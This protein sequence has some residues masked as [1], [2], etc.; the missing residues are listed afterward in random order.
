MTIPELVHRFNKMRPLPYF[1]IEPM[2]DSGE[3]ALYHIEVDEKGVYTSLYMP[4]EDK[5]AAKLNRIYIEW[6]EYLDLDAHIE[7][8]HELCI[9]DAYKANDLKLL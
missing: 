3:Y 4:R 6:D 8:L 7:C 1:E 9:D 5:D 2:E